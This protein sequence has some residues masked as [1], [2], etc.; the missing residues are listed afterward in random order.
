[1]NESA[2][3]AL[4][5]AFV[6]ELETLRDQ[7]DLYR[8]LLL[9]EPVALAGPFQRLAAGGWRLFFAA[10]SAALERR[11][12]RWRSRSARSARAGSIWPRTS[13]IRPSRTRRLMYCTLTWRFLA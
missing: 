1:M 4:P 13:L 3:Q 12:T 8:S 2:I 6:V 9:S 11:A 5:Q 10:A 7:R